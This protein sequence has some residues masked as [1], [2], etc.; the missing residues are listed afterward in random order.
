[1]AGSSQKPRISAINV[2]IWAIEN[3]RLEAVGSVGTD[4]VPSTSRFVDRSLPD[5]DWGTGLPLAPV[6][7]FE[8][9]AYRPGS[10]GFV[11]SGAEVDGEN[12][13]LRLIY[14]LSRRL[15]VHHYLAP[16][17]DK[18]V[19]R[20]HTALIA[21]GARRVEGVSRFDAPNLNM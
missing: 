20:F 15:E 18:A 17:P 10:G 4:G 1:M 19:L 2:R 21:G 6:V 14:R 12:Q 13:E 9:Q 16:S 5:V 3:D 11:F 8:G 7:E